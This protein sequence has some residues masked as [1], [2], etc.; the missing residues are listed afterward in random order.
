MPKIT[1]PILEADLRVKTFGKLQLNEFE[2]VNDRT[3]GIS[4]KMKVGI[5][6]IVGSKF[7][8]LTIGG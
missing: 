5:S 4:I 3:Y 2:R 1:K 6:A 8:T 7:G